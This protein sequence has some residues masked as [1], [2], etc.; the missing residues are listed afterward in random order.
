MTDADKDSVLQFVSDS[1]HLVG[2]TGAQLKDLCYSAALCALRENPDVT[3]ISPEHFVKVV[4]N[5]S[6]STIP[7]HLPATLPRRRHRQGTPHPKKFL[8]QKR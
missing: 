8:Y 7:T 4:S 3:T 5:W 6:S 1:P 2:S